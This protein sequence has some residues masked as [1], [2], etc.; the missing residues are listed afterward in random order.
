MLTYEKDGKK[1][2]C[3]PALFLIYLDLYRIF[4]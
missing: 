1:V 2:N 3:D 4:P